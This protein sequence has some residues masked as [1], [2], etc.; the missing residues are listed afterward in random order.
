MHC[1]FYHFNTVLFGYLC[2]TAEC[3]V[4]TTDRLLSSEVENG[5]SVSLKD[6]AMN[7]YRVWSRTKVSQPFDYLP[8]ALPID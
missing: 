2:L 4:I 7:L 6:T 8:V 3:W 1:V 5:I